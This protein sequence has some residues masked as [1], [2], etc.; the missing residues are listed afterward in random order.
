MEKTI[1]LDGQI[2][3]MFP[4]FPN[5]KYANYYYQALKFAFIL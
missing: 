2:G 4:V 1:Y 3:K 5:K